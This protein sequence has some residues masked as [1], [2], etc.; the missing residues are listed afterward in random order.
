VLTRAVAIKALAGAA[1]LL[2]GSAALAAGTGKLPDAAQQRA[3]DVFSGLGVPAP[4]GGGK[5]GGAGEHPGGGNGHPG[6]IPSAPGSQVRSS[7]PAIVAL[8]RTFVQS[9]KK[10]HGNAMDPAALQTLTAAAGAAANIPAYCATVLADKGDA[11][12]GEPGQPPTPIPT[13]VDS[14]SHGKGHGKSGSAASPDQDGRPHRGP[15]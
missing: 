10:P 15:F 2:V 14:G 12:G 6:L 4:N 11:H 7:E 3:H 1:A 13:S 9:Q 5:R 8:C